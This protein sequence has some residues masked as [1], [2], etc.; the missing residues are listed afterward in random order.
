M[1]TEVLFDS[2]VGI[3]VQCL[4][5]K[6]TNIYFFVLFL[7]LGAAVRLYRGMVSTVDVF[8][9]FASDRKPILLFTCFEGAV[10]TYVLIEHFELFLSL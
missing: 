1:Q 3:Y 8:A 2:Q 7:I 10:F 6:R 9:I 4:I 5:A